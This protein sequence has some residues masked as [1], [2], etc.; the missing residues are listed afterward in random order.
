MTE[1]VLFGLGS[2]LVAEYEESLRRAGGVVSFGIR[3]HHADIQCSDQIR[4]RHPGELNADDLARHYI[5][6]LFSPENRKL[7][8]EQATDL[9]FRVAA[10]LV[11]PTAIVA[12][13]SILGPGCYVNSG[14]VIGAA[15]AF[16]RHV[17]I[18]RGCAIGH[19]NNFAEFVSIG[20]GC[21]TCGNITIG[22]GAMIGAGSVILPKVTIGAG[23][24]IGAGSVVAQDVPA[25]CRLIQKRDT[26]MT[27]L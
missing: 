24:V 20:P 22:P 23:A 8:V 18:N 4:V 19:H 3:N 2:P 5:V 16:G 26:V 7:A 15:C 14:S 12:S 13:N 27:R 17:T 9:G 1:V 11:D 6:P 10:T 25:G 21:V